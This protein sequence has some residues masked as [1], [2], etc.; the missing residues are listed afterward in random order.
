VEGEIMNELEEYQLKVNKFVHNT[1][2][3]AYKL[4]TDRTVNEKYLIVQRI[5][6]R[7]FIQFNR[8]IFENTIPEAVE[9]GDL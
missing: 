4:I 6:N 7:M 2:C 8:F 9:K 3:D 5:S 1:F